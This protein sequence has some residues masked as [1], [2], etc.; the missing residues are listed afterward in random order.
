VLADEPVPVPRPRAGEDDRLFEV[1]RHMRR[2]TTAWWGDEVPR[3]T[4]GVA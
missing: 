4:E 2:L 3:R 1:E